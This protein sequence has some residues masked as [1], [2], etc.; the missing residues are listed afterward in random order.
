M[1]YLMIIV[2][3]MFFIGTAESAEEINLHEGPVG[4]IVQVQFACLDPDTVLAVASTSE[5][6]FE[7]VLGEVQAT[8]TC[9]V[10]PYPVPVE[11]S[12]YIKS[13]KV[14]GGVV[15]VYSFEGAPGKFWYTFMF[16][17]TKGA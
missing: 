5:E 17:E 2:G 12:A 9:I 11:I 10:A 6:D 16:E 7:Q 13:G 8:G 1:K 14:N 3:L 4:N 15:H